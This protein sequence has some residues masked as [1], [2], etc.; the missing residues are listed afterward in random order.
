M[1]DTPQAIRLRDLLKKQ[2]A[3]GS[4]ISG[5]AAW[6]AFKEYAREVFDREGVGLLVQ[7]GVSDFT[8]SPLFYFDPVCQFEIRDAEGEYDHLEQLHCELTC[9]PTDALEDAQA[10]LWSFDYPTADA[11][12]SA[13]EDVPAF[14]L[15]IGQT[16]YS[17]SVYHEEV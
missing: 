4:S 5:N 15:A 12:F 9:P 7:S 13:V 3:P 16:G 11:F 8:G 1:S 14:Q 17:I 6:A 2:G 10:N